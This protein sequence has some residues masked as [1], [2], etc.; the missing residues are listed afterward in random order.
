MDGDPKKACIAFEKVSL[1]EDPPIRI[2]LHRRVLDM[3][4][5]KGRNLIEA[6][7]K[8]KDWSNDLYL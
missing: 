8:Y 7:E 3:A 2:P 6:A 1:L 4:N 5:E